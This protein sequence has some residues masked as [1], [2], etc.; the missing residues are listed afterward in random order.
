MKL[1]PVC[2]LNFTEESPEQIFCGGGHCKRTPSV[3]PV[4]VE[5]THSPT[6]LAFKQLKATQSLATLLIYLTWS[7]LVST[8]GITFAYIPVLADEYGNAEPAMPWFFFGVFGG[9]ILTIWGIIKAS[10][11]LAASRAK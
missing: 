7:V 10:N 3:E 6:D 9:A 1:C 5:S 2:K 11:E 4:A 8:I